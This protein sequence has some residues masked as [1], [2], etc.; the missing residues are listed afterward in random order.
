MWNSIQFAHFF[1]GNEIVYDEYKLI[2]II[3]DIKS[4]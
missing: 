1:N 4:E 2:A 3:F